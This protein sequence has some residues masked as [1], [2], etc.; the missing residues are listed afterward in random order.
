M[1]EVILV[2]EHDNS[3]GTMEKI[4]AHKKGLLH[5][6]FS[7]LLFNTRGEVLIQKRAEVKYHSGGLW[8]NTCCSHPIPG[9][10]IDVA[11]RRR[12]KFEMGIDVQTEFAYKFIYK[13]ALDKELTEHELDHVYIG[14]FDGVPKPNPAEVDDWKFVDFQDLKKDV[15]NHPDAYTYWFRLIMN[16]SEIEHYV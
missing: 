16:H 10:N 12:L 3:I 2:D 13:T 15:N 1:E 8:T 5:R 7:I 9:E 4:E 14:T 6:A 11:T